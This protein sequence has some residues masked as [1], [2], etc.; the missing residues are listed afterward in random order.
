MAS[1][2]WF[3]YASPA[4]F[5]PLAGRMIPWFGG[6]AAILHDDLEHILGGQELPVQKVAKLAPVDGDGL[7]RGG[8]QVEER[9]GPRRPEGAAGVRLFWHGDSRR[10]RAPNVEEVDPTGAGDSA[11]AGCVLALAAGANCIEAALLGNL[12]ASI[13]VQQLATTGTA[14]PAQLPDRLEMWQQQMSQ[15]EGTL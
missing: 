11:T 15:S 9:P 7:D 5:Y 14:T 8:R 2:N 1:L 12:V 6:L 4:T 3:R 10:F 13:T